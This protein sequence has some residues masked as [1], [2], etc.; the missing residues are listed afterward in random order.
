MGGWFGLKMVSVARVR[1]LGDHFSHFP[2]I[3]SPMGRGEEI[4]LNVFCRKMTKET[5]NTYIL[6]QNALT[7]CTKLQ[8][9]KL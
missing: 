5:Y 7:V 8:I 9:E 2:K 3:L 4:F 6:F 1:T